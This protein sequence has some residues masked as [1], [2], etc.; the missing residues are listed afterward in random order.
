MSN[1]SYTAEQQVYYIKYARRRFWCCG[2]RRQKN[3]KGENFSRFAWQDKAKEKS[4]REKEV[5]LLLFAASFLPDRNI[6]LYSRR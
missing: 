4:K 5:I 2:E 3:K 6:L 1:E